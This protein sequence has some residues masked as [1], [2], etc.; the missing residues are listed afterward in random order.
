MKARTRQRENPGMSAASPQPP[1]SL[2]RAGPPGAAPQRRFPELRAAREQR[3]AAVV[4][5][6]RGTFGCPESRERFVEDVWTAPRWT[7]RTPG[8]KTKQGASGVRFTADDP[9]RRA[10]GPA[11]TAPQLPPEFADL[12]RAY[13][14]GRHSIGVGTLQG[15]SNAARLFWAFLTDV[16]P[17]RAGAWSWATLTDQDLQRFERWLA[18]QPAGKLPHRNPGTVRGY[19]SHLI[20]FALWLYGHRIIARISYT[21]ESED[22]RLL[23]RAGARERASL[24]PSLQAL[25][26]LA[27]LYWDLTEGPERHRVSEFDLMIL[28]IIVIT[29]MTGNR[30]GEI[31]SLPLDCERWQ[32]IRRLTKG[33]APIGPGLRA[34]AMVQGDEELVYGLRY[35]PE[36][37]GE[38]EPR[39]K[40]VSPTAAPIVEACI[41]RLRVLGREAR[42]RAAVLESSPDRVPLSAELE[43]KEWLTLQEIMGMLGNTAHSLP[44][45]LRKRLAPKPGSYGGMLPNGR[46][47]SAEYSRAAF[48]EAL[49]EMRE[50][51][52]EPWTMQF[53][54]GTRQDLSASLC[55]VFQE[56]PLRWMMKPRRLLV[57]KITQA[58]VNRALGGKTSETGKSLFDL[59]GKEGAAPSS[60][61][62]HGFRRWLTSVAFEGGAPVEDLTRIFGRRHPK[63]THAYLYDMAAEAKAAG[64]LPS[65]ETDLGGELA[66][67]IRSGRYF[68]PVA[69]TYWEMVARGDPEAADAYLRRQIQSGHVT[70]WGFCKRDLRVE[71]CEKHLACFNACE[72]YLATRR[73]A[74]EVA[75]LEDLVARIREQIQAAEATLA[76]GGRL[77]PGYLED[78]RT[79][80]FNVRLTLEWHRVDESAGGIGPVFPRVPNAHSLPVLSAAP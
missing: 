41:G 37:T 52:T 20:T 28:S 54:D 51:E 61:R 24:L 33:I 9:Q 40:W 8:A 34:K 36:K 44:E 47:R 4:T 58:M 64:R 67:G 10:P 18:Q 65:T 50:R 75:A 30:I 16:A 66:D 53:T 27:D 15:T 17:E 59:Y 35:W 48:A 77:P 45:W 72:H 31:L 2:T 43:A 32:R 57:R 55:V 11:A 63:D 23:G 74:Q 21:P 19:V 29:M 68:G 25:E 62:T 46:G 69:I 39:I 14:V 1:V 78:A 49:Q 7:V 73:N 60:L 5:A 13:C 3:I 42:A 76:A 70:P 6:A 12:L 71:P 56:A 38:T 79:K 26:A 80:L 22:P